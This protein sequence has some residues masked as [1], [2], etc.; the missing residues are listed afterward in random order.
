MW[1]FVNN[2]QLIKIV[3]TM[4]ENNGIVSAVCH[5]PTGLLN[6]KLSNGELL[7][8]GRNP[9]SAKVLGEAVFS[10][11]KTKAKKRR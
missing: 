4:Y 7:I 2:P 1:D 10:A 11:L 8:K 5:D 6:V 3:R 9:V